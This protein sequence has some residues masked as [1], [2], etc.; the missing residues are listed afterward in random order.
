MSGRHEG[1][2]E[3]TTLEDILDH[4]EKRMLKRY[5]K[6]HDFEDLM[7]EAKIWAWREYEAGNR[8]RWDILRIA[9]NRARNLY[10]DNSGSQMLGKPAKSRDGKRDARGDA[11]KA[12]IRQYME[13]HIA[14]HNEKPTTRQIAEATGMQYAN[15]WHHLKNLEVRKETQAAT[16]IDVW[17]FPFDIEEGKVNPPS[18]E[19]YGNFEH[20]LVRR[21]VIQDY[22]ARLP[23]KERA[24]VYY[25]FW[26]D[27]TNQG[28]A[29]GLGGYTA[30]VGA[31]WL[32]KGVER[33][34]TL[35]EIDLDRT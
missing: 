21:L 10:Q 18:Y 27:R 11:S 32:K 24:A 15:V 7:Q 34:R 22:M 2:A 29:D 16:D 30:Q 17:I 20:H 25:K 31:N 9:N 14:L 13:E 4:V 19:D 35:V 6:H 26:E 28:I 5:A 12:K 1:M 8:D 33:L 23:E 3:V